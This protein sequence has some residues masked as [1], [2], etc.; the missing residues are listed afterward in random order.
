MSIDYEKKIKE[1]AKA[2]IFALQN[3]T[4]YG[5]AVPLVRIEDSWLEESKF[6]IRYDLSS[7]PI[8]PMAYFHI[9]DICK[10]N[11][12]FYTGLMKRLPRE[13]Q[14]NWNG[15]WKWTLDWAS[16]SHLQ[17]TRNCN[18]FFLTAFVEMN[19]KNGKEIFCAL[20][21]LPSAEDTSSHILEAK[22]NS[23]LLLFWLESLEI[24]KK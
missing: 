16:T 7:F 24:I 1:M 20:S 18:K 13:N 21:T 8:F 9:G 6:V 10:I 2:K 22:D 17:D 5:K 3:L 14:E 12:N 23:S 19:S 4:K 15:P 11:F